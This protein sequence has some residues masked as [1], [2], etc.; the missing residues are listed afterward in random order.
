MDWPRLPWNN[1]TQS[2]A[3]LTISLTLLIPLL[4]LVCRFTFW[5]K[6]F[7]VRILRCSSPRKR[8]YLNPSDAYPIGFE[9]SELSSKNIFTRAHC[10]VAQRCRLRT[11][12]VRLELSSMSSSRRV[13]AGSEHVTLLTPLDSDCFRVYSSR[14]RLSSSRS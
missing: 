13:T 4:D 10:Y 3:A 1:F 14:A 9:G 6:P 12:N 11:S 2:L 8:G 5:L 7:T